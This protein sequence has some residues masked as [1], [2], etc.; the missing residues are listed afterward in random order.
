MS[1]KKQKP[2]LQSIA[3]KHEVSRQTVHTWRKKGVDIY[4]DSDIEKFRKNQQC[5][6]S[7]VTASRPS[8]IITFEGSET[9]ST[10]SDIYKLIDQAQSYEEARFLKMKSDAKIQA[11]KYEVEIGNYTKNSE[12]RENILRIGSAVKAA[13]LRYESDLPPMIA[14]L[15]E[16]KIQK[17]VREKNN[18]ILSM[19]SNLSKEL[20]K[21]E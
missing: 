16:S 17:V 1:K 9:D 5:N 6:P 8:E 12:I 19:F 18:L 2:T 10:D 14:G 21:D 3:K 11:H 20:Y 7:T 13:L 4:D 15:T